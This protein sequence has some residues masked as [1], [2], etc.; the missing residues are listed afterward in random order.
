MFLPA[1][2][3]AAIGYAG[4]NVVTVMVAMCAAIA[5]YALTYAGVWASTVINIPSIAHWC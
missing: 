4:C 2:C 3:L 5:V 1:A